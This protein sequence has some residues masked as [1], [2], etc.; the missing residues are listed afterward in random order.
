MNL[1][2]KRFKKYLVYPAALS[3]III[4]CSCGAKQQINNSITD[5]SSYYSDTSEGNSSDTDN[6]SISEFLD[7]GDESDIPEI[8]SESVPEKLSVESRRADSEEES[9]DVSKNTSKSSSDTS[10]KSS[11]T[12]SDKST[13]TS[14]DRSNSTVSKSTV[15]SAASTVSTVSTA[16]TTTRTTTY[17][18][19]VSEIESTDNDSRSNTSSTV[20]DN[21]ASSTSSAEPSNNDSSGKKLIVIDAGHQQT[22]NTEQ[23]PV[24]PGA[25]E[26]KAKVSTGT[27]GV[28]SGLAEYELTLDLSLQLGSVLESRGYEVVQI[29]TTN[30]VNISNAERSSIANSYNADAFVR[31][32]AN[33][34]ENSGDNGAMTIC[35]TASNPYNGNLYA[36][37]KAL[38]T[39][40]LEEL[41]AATGCNRKN[42]WETDTMTGINWSQVPVTIVEVGYMTN[43]QE[44][45]L[46]ASPDYQEKIINGIANGIDKYFS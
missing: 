35:Q 28:S 30:D 27:A 34:S 38:S 23:E 41:A 8:I 37:S 33:G 6:L 42:I 11:E 39:C 43:P 3:M 2:F 29:R 31:I 36:Q 16:P 7:N 13:D 45:L 17:I 1:S 10:S 22:A 5:T 46:M 25:S 32:H 20:S 12:T 21:A 44:D 19:T 40:I 4:L 26:T 24:G 9:S 15:S 18:T 14:I